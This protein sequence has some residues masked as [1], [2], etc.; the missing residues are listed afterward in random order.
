M[1]RYIIHPV[2]IYNYGSTSTSYDNVID[3]VSFLVEREREKDKIKLLPSFRRNR[4]KDSV[5]N[6]HIEKKIIHVYLAFS[7]MM[8][9]LRHTISDSLCGKFPGM[10]SINV[11]FICV[12]LHQEWERIFFIFLEHLLSAR[13]IVSKAYF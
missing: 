4:K 5:M 8:N 6:F 11:R 9:I 13:V 1:I 3:L 12:E 10:I 2:S 7:H